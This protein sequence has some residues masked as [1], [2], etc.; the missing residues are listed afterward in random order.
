MV[1]KKSTSKGKGFSAKELAAVRKKLIEEKAKIL[2]ELMN[3]KGDALNKS[4]RDASGDLSGYSFHMADMATDL[5]DREFTLEL[6]EGERERLYE[7]DDAIKRV[8]NKEYGV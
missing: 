7:F 3:L 6:A 5:Y 8:D 4:F 1:K 2:E